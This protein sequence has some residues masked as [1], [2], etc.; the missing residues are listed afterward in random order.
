MSVCWI[1]SSIIVC[2]VSDGNDWETSSLIFFNIN[3]LKSDHAIQTVTITIAGDAR[4][5]DMR[6][7]N[8]WLFVL[9]AGERMLV[10]HIENCHFF[11]FS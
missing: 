1:T 8:D 2:G 4:I 10:Y 6:C 5:M 11:H 9:L 3:D 7:M